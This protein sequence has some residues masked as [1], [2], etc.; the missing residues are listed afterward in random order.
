VFRKKKIEPFKLKLTNKG[1]RVIH[2]NLAKIKKILEETK[3]VNQTGRG[4]RGA[5]YMLHPKRKKIVSA[6]GEMIEYFN[7]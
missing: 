4:Y 2:Q 3:R 6:I 5:F 7:L 1:K